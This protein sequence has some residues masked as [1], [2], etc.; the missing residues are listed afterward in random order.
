MSQ[1]VN[2]LVLGVDS[3]FVVKQKISNASSHIGGDVDF[4]FAKVDQSSPPALRSFYVLYSQPGYIH[5]GNGTS[6]LVPPDP[7]S[8]SK[9][10]IPITE[11][12]RSAQGFN[13]H[14][15][16]IVLF[17]HP[18]Y[19]GNA[20]QFFQDSPDITNQFPPNSPG[21]VSSIIVTGGTWLLWT[22][23]NY[24][25]VSIELSQANG[26]CLMPGVVANLGDKIR[27][28]QNVPCSK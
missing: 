25:G 22:G 21:G 24:T 1:T 23:L 27:S 12:I 4:T 10:S 3:T 11:P 19:K 5:T 14:N 8:Y 17:E 18:E 20:V 13:L 2:P 26:N 6:Y 7:L 16:G 28:V 9:D 15:P